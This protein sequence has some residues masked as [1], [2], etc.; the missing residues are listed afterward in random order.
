MQS[1]L[2]LQRPRVLRAGPQQRAVAARAGLFGFM[3]PKPAAAAPVSQR[4]NEI[5]E[6]LVD[7]CRGT[8]AGAKVP[9]GRREQIAELVDELQGYCMKN[10]LKS[11]LLWGEYEVRRRLQPAAAALGR[12]QSAAAAA[13][14]SGAASRAGDAGS[15]QG[16]ARPGA[17]Q[18][19]LLPGGSP[20]ALQHPCQ[21]TGAP[22][23]PV[24]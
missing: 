17:P 18:Q 12:P 20:G 11:K 24:G 8:D 5:V 4:A 9:A 7:I 23:S 15:R 3:T 6:E 2:R 13:Q 10:P 19:R 21:G 14:G 1:Q 16:A 22:S